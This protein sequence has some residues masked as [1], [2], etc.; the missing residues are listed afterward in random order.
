VLSSHDGGV[1][2]ARPTENVMEQ[3]SACRPER[4]AL[5]FKDT[6]RF[7]HIARNPRHLKET[8]D[9]DILL[10]APFPHQYLP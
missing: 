3:P 8:G 5:M 4:C 6:P 2:L 9:R 10:V 7:Y 1:S